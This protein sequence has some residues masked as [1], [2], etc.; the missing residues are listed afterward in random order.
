MNVELRRKAYSD[1]LKWKEE[2]AGTTALL[3]NGARR[4]GK[5]HLVRKFA[6]NEYR[7]HIIIDFAKID[8]MTLNIF[9][10]HSSD[11]D[12]FFQKLM[13]AKGRKLY[14]RESVVVFDEVQLYPP[15][16]QMIKYLV[17]D[18][19]Y[20][21]IETGSLISIK[22]N[23][24]DIVVP[25][26]EDD[27][28][29]YPLDFEEFLWAMGNETAI[30]YMEECFKELKPLGDAAHKKIMD[31]FRKYMLVGGMPQAVI[32]YV[33]TG[34]FEKTE[35]VKKRILSVYRKDI[36]KYAGGYSQRVNF[37]FDTIPSQLSKGE[38]KYLL[39]SLNK[40]ARYRDFDDA[41]MWLADGMIVNPCVNATDPT[42]G[43]MMSADFTSQKLYMGDTGL[44]VTESLADKD[45]TDED[46][47]KSLL[48]GK[49]GINEGMFAENV[50]AQCLRAN[51]NQLYFYS[52][53]PKPKDDEEGKNDRENEMETG[54]KDD[55]ETMDPT[56]V[57]WDTAV[58]I[59]FLIR[60]GHK[61]CP[62]EVKSSEKIR[63]E[64]LDRFVSRFKGRI[65]QPY[66]LCT[67]DIKVKD[68]I[69][70]MPLYMAALL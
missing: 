33:T 50:V 49:I 15:A 46:I 55:E 5:S 8:E 14:P 56:P 27:L 43:L 17:E 62:V 31:L 60:R 68:G 25:S 11:L 19:R 28:E 52:R 30:P 13:V 57:V 45:S 16:R 2:S 9:K 47:Y 10:E 36:T 1:L 20:D 39:A 53:Y 37:I 65:G 48:L 23:V 67:K 12:D 32:K 58:E 3:V 29:M 64:S 59:D 21:Y 4:V 35:A 24:R 63:H 7:S 6:E 69:V 26:E 40:N 41:F 70:Y 22:A 18:G 42:V 61:I 51:G 54:P 38:K 44:L 66:I 34:S